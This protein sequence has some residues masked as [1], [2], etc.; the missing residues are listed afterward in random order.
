MRGLQ[1]SLGQVTSK[2]VCVFV[3]FFIE[4]KTKK[5]FL[6]FVKIYQL[7]SNYQSKAMQKY[8]K[9]EKIGEGTYGVVFK[10]ILM[11]ILCINNKILKIC[12]I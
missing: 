3:C 8:E 9:L 10:G 2:A 1:Q 7:N 12:K 5:D 11:V 4:G 6:N